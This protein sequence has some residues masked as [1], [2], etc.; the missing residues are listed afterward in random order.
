VDS[1][2]RD[3]SQSD[4]VDTELNLRM[5]EEILATGESEAGL[6]GRGTVRLS[7]TVLESFGVGM[8]KVGESYLVGMVAALR[9][10]LRWAG[11]WTE[12]RH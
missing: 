4:T 1:S 5:L 7:W 6:L 12:L 11:T 8:F 10:V 2:G 9:A 3:H